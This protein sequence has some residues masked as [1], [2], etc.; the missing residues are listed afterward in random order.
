MPSTYEESA[1][2]D[3]TSGETRSAGI[4]G[5]RDDAPDSCP[6]NE[7]S[8]WPSDGDYVDVEPHHNLD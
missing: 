6:E 4:G 1:S 8:G 7:T 2:G 3:E 5:L